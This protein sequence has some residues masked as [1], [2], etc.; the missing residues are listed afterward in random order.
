MVLNW[1][2]SEPY[3]KD[4][5]HTSVAA[6]LLERETAELASSQHESDQETEDEDLDDQ[7]ASDIKL[8][9]ADA[10]A[11]GVPNELSW[12]YARGTKK[13]LIRTFGVGRCAAAC[14]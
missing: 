8:K 5:Q 13:F 3:L 14:W 1:S 9:I 11:T 4:L 7:L 12:A 6:W 10:S 2:G